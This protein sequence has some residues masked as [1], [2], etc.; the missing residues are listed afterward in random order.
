MIHNVA[1]ARTIDLKVNAL[2][3]NADFIRYVLDGDETLSIYWQRFVANHQQYSAAVDQAKYILQHL[4][5]SC[6]FLTCEEIESLK[7][8]IKRTLSV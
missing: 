1:T 4:D 7:K 8:R 3:E 2:L 6:D 5:G